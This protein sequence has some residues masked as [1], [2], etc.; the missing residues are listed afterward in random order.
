MCSQTQ[1]SLN[2]AEDATLLCSPQ[3]SVWQRKM[4]LMIH[5]TL[6]EFSLYY[7][8]FLFYKKGTFQGSFLW[9][10]KKLGGTPFFLNN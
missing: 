7:L 5:E 4:T 2:A 3:Y 8:L 9:D 10:Q 6:Q 1:G